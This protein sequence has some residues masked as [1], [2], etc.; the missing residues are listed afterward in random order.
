[1]STLDKLLEEAELKNQKCNQAM[2]GKHS[3]FL[4]EEE[5]KEKTDQVLPAMHLVPLKPVSHVLFNK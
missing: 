3:I 4:I 2:G 1:M 5:T